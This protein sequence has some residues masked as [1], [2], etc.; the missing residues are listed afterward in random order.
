MAMR[1]LAPR[2]TRTQ[3]HACSSR[4]ACNVSARA[5]RID[6]ISKTDCTSFLNLLVLAACLMNWLKDSNEK[7]Q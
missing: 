1:Q 7:H 6:H 2:D 5:E 4:A 3:V